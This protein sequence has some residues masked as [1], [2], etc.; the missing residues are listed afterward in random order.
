[1]FAAPVKASLLI[2]SRYSCSYNYSY[3]YSYGDR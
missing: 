1:M 3:S 2:C